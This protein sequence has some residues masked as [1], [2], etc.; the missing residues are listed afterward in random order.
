M[1]WWW[2]SFVLDGKGNIPITTFIYKR[3]QKRLEKFFTT[4]NAD[5]DEKNTPN[6]DLFLKTEKL[7]AFGYKV[8]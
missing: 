7:N 1:K 8:I 3:T 5:S 2:N 6:W 4:K